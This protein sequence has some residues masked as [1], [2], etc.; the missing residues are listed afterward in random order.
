MVRYLAVLMMML[1]AAPAL[2]QSGAVGT[3][4]DGCY[5]GKCE[6]DEGYDPPRQRDPDPQPRYEP[7]TRYD[8]GPLMCRTHFG[9]CQMAYAVDIGSGCNCPGL[10]LG[11]TSYGLV[12]PLRSPAT[13]L[14]DLASICATDFGACPM[15]VPLGRFQSCICN[16]AIW[17]ISQ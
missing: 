14:P 13:P 17:G 4:Q 9:E 7:E 2:A 8:P 10:A 5:F 1:F 15:S 3:G 11:F 16:G 6:G 12:Q